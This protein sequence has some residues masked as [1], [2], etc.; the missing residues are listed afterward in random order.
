[1]EVKTAMDDFVTRPRSKLDLAEIDRRREAVSHAKANSRLEGQFLSPES[2]ALF[3]S[4]IQGDIEVPE[5]MDRM[6]ARRGAR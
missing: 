1:M 4:F 6:Q 5:L 2:E 3:D